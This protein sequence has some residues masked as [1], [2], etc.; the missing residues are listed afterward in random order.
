MVKNIVEADTEYDNIIRS[1]RFALCLDKTR[2][3]RSKLLPPGGY[4]IAIKYIITKY[5]N[6]IIFLRQR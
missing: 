2:E 6:I 4:P 3:Q 5:V 1:K